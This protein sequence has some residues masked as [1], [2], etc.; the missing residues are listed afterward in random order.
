[1]NCKLDTSLVQH[2][3]VSS[4]V[5]S[6]YKLLHENKSRVCRECFLNLTELNRL[7]N[8][9]QVFQLLPLTIQDLYQVVCTSKSLYKV[10]H[11]LLHQFRKIQYYL[12][13]EV[14]STSETHALWYNRAYFSGHSKWPAKLV[15]ASTRMEH[16]EE[17]LLQLLRTRRAV[18]CSVLGCKLACSPHLAV[19]DIIVCL[20]CRLADNRVVELPLSMLEE[21]S[22]HMEQLLPYVT[23]LVFVVRYYK[24]SCTQYFVDFFLSQSAKSL[25]FRTRSLGADAV[26]EGRQQFYT[27]IRKVLVNSLTSKSIKCF[28]TGTILRTT[29]SRS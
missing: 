27:S 21:R 22:T 28:S 6:Y 11:Y 23:I 24:G 9:I 2:L 13:D 26:Y 17:D 5:Y 16:A 15:A 10:A 1:M 29:S 3:K 7:Q 12:P 8:I 4:N 25:D 20:H 19:E 18:C 14:V